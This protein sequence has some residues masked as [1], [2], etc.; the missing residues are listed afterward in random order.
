MSDVTVSHSELGTNQGNISIIHM[1]LNIQPAN[2]HS[3]GMQQEVLVTSSFQSFFAFGK[4][5]F[6]C[7]INE[8]LGRN[9]VSSYKRDQLREFISEKVR[10]LWFC[11]LMC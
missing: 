3:T 4:D 10:A 6:A 1:G 5:F 7:C 8:L 9:S 2:I 11:R